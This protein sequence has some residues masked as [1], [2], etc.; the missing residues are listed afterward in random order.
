MNISN[1]K[2]KDNKNLRKDFCEM[3]GDVMSKELI[4]MM[5]NYEKLDYGDRATDAIQ[6]IYMQKLAIS[7]GTH[8]VARLSVIK[9]LKNKSKSLE[10]VE[11]LETYT[12]N[13]SLKKAAVNKEMNKV[14]EEIMNQQIQTSNHAEEEVREKSFLREACEC[15]LM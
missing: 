10:D 2:R 12:S 1:F 8:E 15:R 13:T 11:K 5:K 3:K 6:L 9:A 4:S 7:I 14:I